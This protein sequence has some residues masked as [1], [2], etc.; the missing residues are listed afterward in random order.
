MLVIESC[1]TGEAALG[2]SPIAG[3]PYSTAS[4]AAMLC[5]VTTQKV[6]SKLSMKN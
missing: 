6:L 2:A 5:S 1:V 3:T 4:V